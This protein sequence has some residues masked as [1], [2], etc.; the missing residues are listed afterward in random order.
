MTAGLLLLAAASVSVYQD[1]QALVAHYTAPDT[2]VSYA[3]PEQV[4]D[5]LSGA[6]HTPARAGDFR[7]HASIATPDVVSVVQVT[8]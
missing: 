2:T 5:T 8:P 4:T 6:W 3:T 7:E 1:T